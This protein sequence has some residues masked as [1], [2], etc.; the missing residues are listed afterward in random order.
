MTNEPNSVVSPGRSPRVSI[1]MPAFNASAYIA[2]A[3]E[4]VVRQTFPEW[5]LLVV[6]DGSKDDT[7]R[8]VE[9]YVRHDNRVQLIRQPNS[10]VSVARNRALAEAR[11]EFISLLDSDDAWKPAFLTRVME[12]FAARPDVSVVTSN[13]LNRGGQ[14]DGQ[15]YYAVAAGSRDISLLEMIERED[16]VCIMSVFRRRVFES[17]GGFDVT[18]RSNEDYDYWLRAAA[19]GFLFHQTAEP[20]GFYRRRGDSMS[21]DQL[22]MLTGITAVLAKARERC[23]GRPR[24]R[25]AIDRQLHRFECDRLA[26]AAKAALRRGDYASASANFKS[27]HQRKGGLRLGLLSAASRFA[28]QPLSWLD[29]TGRAIRRLA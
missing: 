19:A 10:G 20:M 17:I 21:A 26:E 25:D 16:A 1:L 8:V 6:D 27:L 7:C 29:R 5:E 15:P 18:L 13:V 28:P 2:A 14:L 12:T 4:S 24:E 11:G 9:R 22:A 23:E 3:I